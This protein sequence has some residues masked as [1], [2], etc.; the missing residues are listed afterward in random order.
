MIGLLIPSRPGNARAAVRLLLLLSLAQMA[1]SAKAEPPSIAVMVAKV[2]PAVVSVFTVRAPTHDQNKPAAMAADALAANRK[3]GATGSGYIVDPS[4]Y[5]ATN[6]HVIE[7]AIRLFVVTADGVRYPAEIAGMADQADIALLRIDAGQKPL[8]FV[9][10][11]DSSLMRPGDKV[12]AIGSPL[13]FDVTVT[14]GIIS[15]INRD[16]MES[17]F[18]SYLQ[19]DAAM[20]HGNSG[21]PLV[22]MAGE[23]IG[24]ASVI[25]SPDPGSSGLG[26]AIPSN[27][28]KFVY[29]RLMRAGE[30]SAGM[31]PIHTQAVTWMLQ[32]ALDTPDL[33]GALVTSVEDDSGGMPL[34]KIQAGDVIRTFNEQQ[35]LDPR[36]LARKAAQAPVGSDVV[37]GVIRGGQSAAVH[38]TIHTYPKAKPIVLDNDGP[39]ILGLDL[40][41]SQRANG[42][43]IVTVASVD[44]AGMAAESGL[45]Q[46]DIIVEVQQT[47]VSVPDE[48]W[49]ILWAR[50][51]VKHRFTAVLV[52][53]DNKLSWLSVAVPR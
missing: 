27:A 2:S 17:P 36:D 1:A 34:D 32:Q 24:M 6:K 22:Y 35:I 45:V 10:F 12:F 5:I 48:A 38:V 52:E 15:A 44:P 11:G 20:N 16:V 47:A 30:V 26:F 49:R 53:H 3:S 9:Q 33:Q 28:L 19:T 21:G 43:P 29:G 23:V 40:A 39:R 8:P 31:L 50:S 7:G 4:G 42:Q 25:F 46:G 13:G 14:S 51:A 41:A 18:D 37:L